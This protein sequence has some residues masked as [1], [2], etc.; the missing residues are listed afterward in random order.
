MATERRFGGRDFALVAFGGAGPLH[1]CA[2]A[3]A[4]GMAAV[5]VP[6]RAGVLSAVGLLCAPMQHDLVPEPFDHVDGWVYPPTGPGLGIEVIEEVVDGFR[7]EKTL[8]V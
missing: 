8:A 1:A 6:P 4:L 2:L 5:I 7:S 3:D